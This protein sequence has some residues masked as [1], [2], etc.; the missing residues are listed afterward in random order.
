MSLP[1]RN[2]FSSFF[3]HILRIFSGLQPQRAAKV[4]GVYGFSADIDFSF[5]GV[6]A[7]Y[8]VSDL[9]G[10]TPEHRILA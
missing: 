2:D 3:W 8:L 9:A 1:S 7:E 4:S 10:R 6:A 5:T